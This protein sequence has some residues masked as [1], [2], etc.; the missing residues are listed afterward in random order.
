MNNVDLPAMI[1]ECVDG[2]TR[3]VTPGEIKARA[4]MPSR[5]GPSR[6]GP[7][8]PGRSAGNR[9]KLAIGVTGLAAAG[10]VA[11]LVASQAGG[12]TATTRTVLT[13]AVVKHMASTSQAAMTSGQAD[14]DWTSSGLPSVAQQ[15]SFNGA[16]W[17]DVLNPG[18]PGHDA[19]AGN[20]VSWTGESIVRVVDGREYHWPAIK[21]TARGPDYVPGWMVFGSAAAGAPLSIPDPRTLLAVLSPAAGFVTEG[22]STV[23]GVPVSRLSATTPGAVALAPLND[24]IQSEPDGARLSAIDVWVDANDVVL[25]AQVTVSGTNGSGAPQSATVT[26]TF[27][28]IGQLQPITPPARYTTFGG[29]H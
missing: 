29:K 28:Q 19:H 15:V 26:V 25:K 16:N 9:P 14:I 6:P 27:S 13:A 2:G 17:N 8:R 10:A 18:R 1:R 24:I 5:P 11:A 23:N 3:P 21:T 22:K 12:G 4:A 20:L 7:S